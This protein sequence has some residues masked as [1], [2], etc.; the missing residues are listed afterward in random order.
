MPRS[1]PCRAD[2]S[3]ADAWEPRTHTRGQLSRQRRGFSKMK[4]GEGHPL[5]SGRDA[6]EGRHCAA[7]NGAKH[8][9]ASQRHS[10]H[11]V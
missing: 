11:R 6:G 1:S 5:V 7:V 9:G 8:R 2:L 3:R 4:T 10:E